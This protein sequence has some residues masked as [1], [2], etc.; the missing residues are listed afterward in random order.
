MLVRYIATHGND[1]KDSFE[2]TWPLE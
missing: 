2:D 1:D